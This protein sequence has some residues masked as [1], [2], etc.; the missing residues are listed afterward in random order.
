[1]FIYRQLSASAGE[2]DLDLLRLSR[3]VG[4]LPLSAQSNYVDY[5]LA[6]Y[7]RYPAEAVSV[8]DEGV[9]NGK[10]VPAASQNTREILAV[11]R[12]KL[13]ADKASIP[14]TIAGATGAKGTFKSVMT[15]ADL[16]YGYK[17]Y[18]KAA[19]LYKLALTKPGA[20]VE[21]ANFRLGLSLAQAG[22]K[23]GAQAAFG[24]VSTGP[25]APLASYGKVWASK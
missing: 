12:P 9:A 5:A 18:A 25:Y 10:L 8:L 4:A 3:A 21:Q 13:A 2:T 24:A 7:L 14:A 1:L 11:S 23:A 6:S 16:V 17:D 19:E 15:A 22:N 20:N